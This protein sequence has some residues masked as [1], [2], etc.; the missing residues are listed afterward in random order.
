MTP[1]PEFHANPIGVFVV[2]PRRLADVAGD[3]AGLADRHGRAT[4]GEFAPD[5][6][7]INIP[8]EG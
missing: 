8:A 5:A 2:E 1:R 4:A 7:V 6:P 3:R